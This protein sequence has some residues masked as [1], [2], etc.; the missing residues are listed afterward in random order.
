MANQLSRYKF[1]QNFFK[2]IKHKLRLIII[3]LLLA[4]CAVGY[5]TS[6]ERANLYERQYRACVNSGGV[7][8]EYGPLSGRCDYDPLN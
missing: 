2:M 6:L 7:W 5:V 3:I 1:P 8:Y 4:G